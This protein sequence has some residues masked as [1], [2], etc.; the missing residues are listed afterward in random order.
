MGL[1]YF[2][3]LTPWGTEVANMKWNTGGALCGARSVLSEPHRGRHRWSATMVA[4]RTHSHNKNHEALVLVL[5][6]VRGSFV[7]C[8]ISYRRPLYIPSSSVCGTVRGVTIKC[9]GPPRKC[10]CR[11]RGTTEAC[12]TTTGGLTI[13]GSMHS[14]LNIVQK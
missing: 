7:F 13:S 10:T 2:L 9:C 12:A 5:I 11:N 8:S 1:T 6:V 14:L 4:R 3:G